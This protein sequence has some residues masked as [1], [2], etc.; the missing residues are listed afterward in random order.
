MFAKN[1]DILFSSSEKSSSANDASAVVFFGFCTR[2]K[3]L[4][5]LKVK[6]L[7]ETA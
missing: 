3:L 1:A 4:V 7:L 5:V 2:A 6:I